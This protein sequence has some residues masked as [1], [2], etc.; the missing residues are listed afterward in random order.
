MEASARTR[1]GLR[2]R[3]LRIVVGVLIGF[4]VL[5]AGVAILIRTL[6]ER[7]TRY[8]GKFVYEW[9]GQLQSKNP[10]LS[11]TANLALNRTIIPA[12]T[13]A[14]VQDTNDSR[15]RAAL[16]EYLNTLPNVN[17]FYRPA[18]RRR[19]EAASLLG[20]FGPAANA[21]TPLLLQVLRG[22][23]EDV[24]PSAAIALGKIQ[25]DPDVAIPLLI[26]C[27]DDKGLDDAA[28]LAL[29][30]YGAQAKAAVP[31]LLQLT[32]IPDK[33]LHHAVGLALQKIDPA[34]A[35][36]AGFR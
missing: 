4:T 15:L 22:P 16:I 26:R 17:I 29:A 24:R 33:D 35:A 12:L 2:V 6:G 32:K 8:E 18:A 27:L 31:K 3:L 1:T 13:R 23:D 20:Q 14:M 19:A 9:I 21:A 34:A 30:E 7:D 28:A 36:Q 25:A 11:N 5:I 10:A